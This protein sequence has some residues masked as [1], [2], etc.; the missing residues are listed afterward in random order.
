MTRNSAKMNHLLKKASK[1]VSAK[2]Y[3]KENLIHRGGVNIL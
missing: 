1:A 3:I 2:P